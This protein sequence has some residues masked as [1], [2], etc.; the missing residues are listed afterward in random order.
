MMQKLAGFGALDYVGMEERNC[1]LRAKV[2]DP[3][4]QGFIVGLHAWRA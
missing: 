2:F 3:T 4:W 1:L